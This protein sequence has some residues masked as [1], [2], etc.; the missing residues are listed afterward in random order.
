M[1]A[2]PITVEAV[3][4][5]AKDA[6]TSRL[7]FAVTNH[8]DLFKIVEAVQSR[9]FLDSDKAAALA[10]GL[11]LFSKVALEMRREPLFEPLMEPLKRFTRELKEVPSDTRSPV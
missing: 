3:A 8:D 4:P 2:Y 5:L 9:N 1:Y 7:Q 10:L 6:E 11:K